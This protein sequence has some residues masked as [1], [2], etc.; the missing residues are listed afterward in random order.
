MI[1]H[2]LPLLNQLDIV[3]ASASPRRLQLLT[4]LGFTSLIV[5]PST[6]PETLP[7][8]LY[9]PAS[10][11]ISTSLH[12]AQEVFSR[13]RA[14]RPLHLLISADTVVVDAVDGRDIIVEKPRDNEDAR[15]M[16]SSWS[17]RSHRVV[18]GVTLMRRGA[19]DED[20]GD[21]AA[22]PVVLSFHVETVV[23]FSILS[24]EVVDAY[25]ASGE[26]LDK[27]GAYGVQGLGS[28]LIEG[29]QGDYFNVVGLPVNALCQ[30]LLT[31]TQPL[32]QRL[33]SPADSWQ[34]LRCPHCHSA[35]SLPQSA[36]STRCVS[37]D[38]N[39]HSKQHK[40]LPKQADIS[41]LPS[42][43]GA[44]SETDSQVSVIAEN[45]R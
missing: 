24:S 19:G 11:A 21:A 20:G 8:H 34:E 32:L 35:V 37:C 23:R 27:A 6:F 9:T 33:H 39:V 43:N 16:L 17:G 41:P 36:C 18:T 22:Q 30:Q 3:L 38:A 4:G 42:D 45:T 40:Q 26:P 10:Y 29:M 44:R 31:F 2:L 13:H 28:Q 15:R 14:G 7:H 1:I 5:I 25:V 12:K